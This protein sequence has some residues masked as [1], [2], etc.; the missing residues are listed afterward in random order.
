MIKSRDSEDH[1]S[2]DMILSKIREI[3][4]FSYYCSSFLELGKKF[5][6]ELRDDPTP[7]VSIIL[8][9]GRL[10]YK[11]FGKEEHSFDCFSYVMELCG[12]GF[13]D[14]LKL[15]DHDFGL[16][17]SSFKYDK[18]FTQGH[19]AGPSSKKVK[20]KKVVII[21]KKTR[22]W[23]NRDAVFWGKYLISK[24][25]LEYFK[26]SPISYYWINDFR[27]KCDLSYAFK[28]GS[29]YKI[30]SPHDPKDTKWMSNTTEK[31]IQGFSKL[32]ETGKLCILTSSFKDVMCLYEMGISAIALQTE[33]L[34]PSEKLIKVLAERFEKVAVLYDNDH[35]KKK[36]EGQV[37]AKKIC[38]KYDLPNILL[39][40][41]DGVKDPSDMI[42]H[43][44][45]TKELK[46]LIHYQ[47][48]ET[49]LTEK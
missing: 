17:L 44:K 38:L 45:G 37:M 39:P 6:S 5:S 24:K 22:P 26:V 28:I 40:K 25:T 18:A 1:L 33:M 20:L 3:D 35:E 48:W 19:P 42:A 47:I 36:N 49:R 23:D 10:L 12:C 2:R 46:M 9:K 41:I 34:M 13:F 8:W 27:I 15:I 4:I 32:P 21:K 31:H 29:K 7:S 16:G 43:C 14:A 11:D 30:Y